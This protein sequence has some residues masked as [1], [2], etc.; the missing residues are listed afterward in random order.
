MF[1]EA[2]PHALNGI[3]NV[4]KLASVFYFKVATSICTYKGEILIFVAKGATCQ[5][6]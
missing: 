1:W 4:L 3:I 6:P 2:I 5:E